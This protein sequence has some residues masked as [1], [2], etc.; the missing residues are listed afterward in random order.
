MKNAPQIVS[1]QFQG[2]RRLRPWGVSH[3]GGLEAVKAHPLAI[4][5]FRPDE[6]GVVTSGLNVRLAPVS[7]YMRSKAYVDVKQIF[8]PYQAVEKL[9]L[10]T[11]D[12]AGVTEMTRRRLMNGEGIGLETEGEITKAAY[13]N[14]RN[15]SSDPRVQKSARLAYLAAI[16]HLRLVAY[17]N[18][19]LLTKADTAIQPA[20]LT[21]N[22]LE[23]FDGVLEPEN[24][25]DGAINLTGSLP[26]KGISFGTTTANGSG[27]EAGGDVVTYGEYNVITA[28]GTTMT[29]NRIKL[30]G[31]ADNLSPALYAD[32]GGAGDLTLRDM[33]KSKKLDQL[34][35]AFAGMVKSDP[36]HG[37][38]KVE[39]AL[40]GI[41]VDFDDDCHVVYDRVHEISPSHTRPTDGASINDISAHFELNER[42]STI[43]PRSELGGQLVTIV[44]IKPLETLQKQPDP[45]Q[46]E[47]WTLVN[48][49]HDELALDEV[50]L[51]RQ[52]LESNVSTADQDTPVFWV[53]HNSLKHK[54]MAQGANAQQIAG[55]ELKSS[56]WTYEV[57]TSVTPDNVS[58]PESG[59]NMYPFFNWAGAHAEYQFDQMASISTPLARGPSPV[60]RI[61]LFATDPTLVDG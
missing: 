42:F 44:M 11:Q 9:E 37:E 10:D 31:S 35:R 8:V 28:D 56:M 16:N 29:N 59:I 60:E 14:G 49:I 4:C 61:Q 45:A 3:F 50:L 52:D 32:L 39:R 46:T 25:V 13:I 48:K 20:I 41:S 36:I 5:R 55:V 54:Y 18:A 53:G 2:Q 6:G 26:V 47:A 30:A 43:V 27:S 21:A 22:I 1:D 15:V 51:T 34:V 24:L 58:Y 19:T 40:Y 17:Y 23:R 33:M 12:D 38:E 7:G 57:P